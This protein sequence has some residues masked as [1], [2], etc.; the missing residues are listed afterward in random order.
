MYPSA[1]LL[2]AFLSRAA[3]PIISRSRGAD[4]PVYRSSTGGMSTPVLRHCI[5]PHKGRSRAGRETRMLWTVFAILL[6]LW[7]LGWGF[8]VAGS[9]IHLILVIA[10]VVLLIQIIT[11]RRAAV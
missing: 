8:H 10:V 3:L 4:H 2:T 6:L 9:L 5:Q 7:L 11:G 1:E